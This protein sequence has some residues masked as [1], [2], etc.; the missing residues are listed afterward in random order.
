[1]DTA[2]SCTTRIRAHTGCRADRGCGSRGMETP[3]NSTCTHPHKLCTLPTFE[4][5]AR[6]DSG[7]QLPA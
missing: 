1:M 7:L 2:T 6:L 3:P 5:P 4:Q